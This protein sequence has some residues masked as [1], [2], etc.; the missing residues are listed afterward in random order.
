MS[1]KA[2]LDKVYEDFMKERNYIPEYAK[3]LGEQHPEFLVKWFDTR[4]VFRGKGVLPEKFKELLLVA[5]AAGRMVEHS[6][7][8]H[9]KTAMSS[10]ATKEEVL[11]AAFCA[12]LIGGMP[13]LSLCTNAL[14]KVLKEQSSIKK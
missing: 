7:N 1:T 9:T 4:R 12:W 5:G 11:E 8:M 6:V 3:F 14:Q 10:G 2:E 13:S